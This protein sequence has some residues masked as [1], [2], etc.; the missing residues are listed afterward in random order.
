MRTTFSSV[1]KRNLLSVI[2]IKLILTRQQDPGKIYMENAD[3][4]NVMLLWKLIIS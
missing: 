2:L 3:V 1:R 4:R